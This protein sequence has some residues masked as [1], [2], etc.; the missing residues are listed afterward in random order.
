MWLT[1]FIRN[2]I[3]SVTDQVKD[4]YRLAV[5]Q[6][7]NSTCRF[8]Y[9]AKIAADVSFGGDNVIF[10]QVIIG[11]ATIGAHTYIQ[12]YSA[13]FNTVI[14]NFCS[15]APGVCIGPGMH[16]LE[17]VS[18]HPAFYLKNTPLVRV[19]SAEDKFAT[20]EKVTIGHDVWIGQHVVILDG[21]KVG[22]GAV[23]AAG[24]VVTKDV[25]AYAIVGG[26]PAKFIKYRFEED[27]CRQLEESA[28]W[29]YG[30]ERLQQLYQSFENPGR[31]LEAISR[32]V[33]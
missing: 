23:I 13:I 25:P 28:W 27:V 29:D 30:N 12:R 2:F 10:E 21:V 16:N 15:I 4:R 22:N 7:R 31:F 18:T 9:S 20:G 8:H 6:Q 24:A 11:Q 14:G 1:I 3:R 17:G 26:V 33:T 19:F 32:K 5:A